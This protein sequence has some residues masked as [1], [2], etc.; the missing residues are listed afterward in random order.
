MY[1]TPREMQSKIVDASQIRVGS[2]LDLIRAI[3]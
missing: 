3:F 2:G 1:L